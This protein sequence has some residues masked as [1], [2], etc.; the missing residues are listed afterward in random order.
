MS[1]KFG[2]GSF[3]FEACVNVVDIF[4][5]P[6]ID[7]VLLDHAELHRNIMKDWWMKLLQELGDVLD[8]GCDPK[9]NADYQG[10]QLL[11]FRHLQCVG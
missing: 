10:M 3:K 11:P 9:L 6:G 1:R 2:Q 4:L 7:D 5:V 8:R